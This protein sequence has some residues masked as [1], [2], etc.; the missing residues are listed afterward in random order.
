ME[1]ILYKGLPLYE[2]ECTEEL[3]LE[4]IAFTAKP[5]ITTKGFY[6]S[7]NTGMKKY[8]FKLDEE[9]QMVAGPVIIP[10]YIMYRDPDE[11]DIEGSY[12]KFTKDGIKKMVHQFLEKHGV[13]NIFNDDHKEG[14]TVNSTIYEMWFI[15]DPK[16]DKS[17]MW[18]FDDL[19]VGTFFCVSK[20]HSSEFW[21]KEVKGNAK[22]GFSVEG[23]FQW[24]SLWASEN[25]LDMSNEDFLSNLD[26]LSDQEIAE[27]YSTIKW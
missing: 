4:K 9:Q 22:F 19:E 24:K 15:E 6:F 14:S 27:L 8:E 10:G 20:V 17:N 12:V 23:H 1:Q 13:N 2:L 11:I 25:K 5:A 7:D 3:G 21:E 26:K 18:G 16:N